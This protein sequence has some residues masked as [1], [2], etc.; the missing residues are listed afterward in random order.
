MGK[1]LPTPNIEV[2]WKPSKGSQ[3]LALDARANIIFYTGTRGPGKSDAQLMRFRA[4]VGMGYGSAWTGIIFDEEYKN[5]ED[6]VAKSKKWFYR[7]NDGAKWH[8]STAAYYWEWPTGERLYF[9]AAKKADDYWNYHGHEYPFI[10]WNELTKYP[11]PEL[12]DMMMSTNRSGFVPGRNG[13]PNIPPIPLE[14]FITS[15]PYGVGHNWVKR[16]FIDIAPYGKIVKTSMRVEVPGA[17]GTFVEVTRTQVSLFGNWRENPYLD[18][19]YIATLMG[20]RNKARKKAWLTGDWNIVAGGAFDDVWEPLTHVLPR[21]V[22]PKGWRVDRGFDWGSSHPFYVGWF[23]ESDGTAAIIELG[24]EAFEFC[25]RRGSIIQCGE[26]YG[27]DPE[28][29]NK[30]IYMSSQDIAKG[31]LLREE[32]WEQLGWFPHKPYPGPA[33]NQIF[34]TTQSDE[35]TIAVKMANLGVEWERSNKSP[36]SRINGL[37]LVRDRLEQTTRCEGKGLY[38]MD[39]CT[40]AI[41]TIPVLPRDKVK[42]DDVDTD[43]E[44]H[45]YDVWRYR[46]LKSDVVPET[47]IQ[48][49]FG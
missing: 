43:A 5:L 15:N 13:A 21:F 29:P 32:Y 4:R 6:L 44:D 25:P 3:A 48:F 36:G 7:F 33:D 47:K 34:Q 38:V 41:S 22:V 49:S 16:R 28:A 31:I 2:V 11:D 24:G 23:A 30:G 17:Q 39:H 12:F 19:V 26:W 45:P 14:V 46:V 18:P 10:G 8:S 37:Q 20:E 1:L 42:L 40:S 9:R 35:L 27:C